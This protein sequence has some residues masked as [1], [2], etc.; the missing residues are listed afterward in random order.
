MIKLVSH[1]SDIKEFEVGDTVEYTLGPA[2]K[3]IGVIA[4][5]DSEYYSENENQQSPEMTVMIVYPA[6]PDF[7]CSRVA[8]MGSFEEPT[9][10]NEKLLEGYEDHNYD[11]CEPKYLKVIQQASRIKTLEQILRDL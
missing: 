5:F 7:D 8:T 10:D 4:G 1:R 9:I 6:D 3:R 2:E 11:W